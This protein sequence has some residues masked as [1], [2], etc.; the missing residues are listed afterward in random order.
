MS[1]IESEKYLP[2]GHLDLPEV[3]LDKIRL[4]A[5]S[6]LL[7]YPFRP[8]QVCLNDTG[9][10]ANFDAYEG[11]GTAFDDESK[12]L[13]F[14]EKDFTRW[15]PE[16][17]NTE[18][19]LQIKKIEALGLPVGRTRLMQMKPRSCYSFHTDATERIHLV[20]NPDPQ[21]VMIFLPSTVVQIPFDKK[22]HVVDTTK[23]HSAMNGGKLDRLHLVIALAEEF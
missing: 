3:D 21:A 16:L 13:K 1:L 10:S 11:L 2:V 19:L 9:K 23:T 7:K 18:I 14:R 8:G 20:I 5:E 17:E 12:K 6:F 15:S 22:F 4:E